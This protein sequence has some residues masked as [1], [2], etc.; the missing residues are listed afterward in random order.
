MMGL[1]SERRQFALGAV[2]LAAGSSTRMGRPKML[3]P[4]EGTTVLGHLIGRW[5]DL[6]AQVAVV[7]AAGDAGIE[8]ELER[9]EFPVE[10]G[11]TNCDTSRG[12]FSSIRCAAEWGGWKRGLTHWAIVLGDQPHLRE[13]TLKA[14][15]DFAKLNPEKICQPGREGRARH[16]VLLP[17]AVFTE[18]RGSNHKTLKEF[19][20]V[21]A[22]DV[23]L[24]ELDDA[25]LEVDIDRPADY[26]RA[27]KM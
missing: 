26:E 4:W 13:A 9:L 5:T 23:R 24:I 19:L 18:L 17:R 1:M 16:P 8:A 7:R 11:I 27:R 2:I 3:M 14:V 10:D 25:G 15:I 12:M 20:Q 22:D 21:F 6:A